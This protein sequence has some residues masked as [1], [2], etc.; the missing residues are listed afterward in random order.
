MLEVQ[1]DGVS[2]S[3]TLAYH[4]IVVEVIAALE[5][6]DTDYTA[7]QFYATIGD[8]QNDLTKYFDLSSALQTVADKF[9]P[10]PN[11]ATYPRI[12]FR[13]EAW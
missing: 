13:I 10:T 3:V 9:Q 6:V 1:V 2:P 12:K 5:G 11:A 8:E 7:Q 4:R